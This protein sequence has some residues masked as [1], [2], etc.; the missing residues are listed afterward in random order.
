MEAPASPADLKQARGVRVE[1]PA[2]A[3]PTAN[4]ASPRSCGGL[5]GGCFCHCKFVHMFVIHC[6]AARSDPVMSH[7]KRAS[8]DVP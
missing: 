3:Y 4:I 1:S 2:A 7:A 5:P 6:G 8:S